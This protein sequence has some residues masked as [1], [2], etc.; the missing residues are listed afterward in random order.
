MTNRSVSNLALQES[1]R[2]ALERDCQG[3][4][5]F[6]EVKNQFKEELFMFVQADTT[7]QVQN[8]GL[9]FL[10]A[11]PSQRILS[12]TY[13]T[14][15]YQGSATAPDGRVGCQYTWMVSLKISA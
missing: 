2:A 7:A 11:Y 12:M 5:Y 15:P 1:A 4:E 10:P 3:R 6:E 13:G 9:P 8:N 14:E